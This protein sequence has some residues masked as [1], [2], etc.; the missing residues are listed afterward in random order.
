MVGDTS[1]YRSGQKPPAFSPSERLTVFKATREGRERLAVLSVL[2]CLGAGAKATTEWYKVTCVC[3]RQGND[4]LS[5][6]RGPGK[7]LA[8]AL[9]AARGEGAPAGPCRSAACTMGR[10]TLHLF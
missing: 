9:A 4:R 2:V 3:Q 10:D 8:R 7:G 5:Q 6:K 1:S